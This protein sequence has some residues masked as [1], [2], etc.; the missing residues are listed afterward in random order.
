MNFLE[1]RKL[2]KFNN[3]LISQKD[4]DLINRLLDSKQEL[5]EIPFN[6]MIA[7]KIKNKHM[8]YEFI[9]IE[10]RI[11]NKSINSDNIKNDLKKY[12]RF[13]G[14]LHKYYTMNKKE[15]DDIISRE[16]VKINI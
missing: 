13:L 12:E 6:I 5:K 2:Y 15:L 1:H 4:K 11:I 9:E 7:I 10:K 16:S 14:Y 8:F 3:Q